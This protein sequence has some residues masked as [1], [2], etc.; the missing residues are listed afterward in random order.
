MFRFLFFLEARHPIGFASDRPDRPP[1]RLG[2]LRSPR[3]A[4]AGRPSWRL[5]R[6]GCD[7]DRPLLLRNYR[8]VRRRQRLVLRLPHLFKRLFA[9]IYW[10]PRSTWS[11]QAAGC[12]PRATRLGQNFPRFRYP[13]P[14]RKPVV[15]L[16]LTNPARRMRRAPVFHA[17]SDEL[18]LPLS[19]MRLRPVMVRQKCHV[20]TYAEISPGDLRR[21][22]PL[23][24]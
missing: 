24:E 8:N 7:S 12:S 20:I 10:L 2:L 11:V 4:L 21:V 6:R 18:R 5:S 14:R 9:R 1:A 23:A 22:P 17:P 15:C 19:V 13:A 16:S 3:A